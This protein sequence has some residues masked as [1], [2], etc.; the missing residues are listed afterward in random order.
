M[1]HAKQRLPHSSSRSYMEVEGQIVSPQL[2]KNS[3]AK[4][5]KILEMVK[6]NEMIYHK[7]N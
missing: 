4:C 5:M 1:P 7:Q 6:H 2:L 3:F